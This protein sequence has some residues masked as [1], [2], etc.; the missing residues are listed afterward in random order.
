MIERIIEMHQK[1]EISPER[2]DNPQCLTDEEYK[3]RCKAMME[4]LIE[5]CQEVFEADKNKFKRIYD[6]FS[7][8]IDESP[9]RF[10][11]G[12]TLGDQF[13]ALIDLSIFTMGTAVEHRFPFEEGFNAV[14]DANM[15]KR[16]FKEG[17]PDKRG[18]KKDLVKPQ[19]WKA[20]NLD[21]ILDKHGVDRG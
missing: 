8:L 6:L 9:I 12:D 20:P 16:L 17:D 4:E 13:D 3:F 21:R 18:F 5:Y 15:K 11:V 2:N 1:F 7:K 10:D 14:M 19:G